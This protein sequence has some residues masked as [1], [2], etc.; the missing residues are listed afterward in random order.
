MT[1]AETRRLLCE[2]AARLRR[3]FP[4][5]YKDVPSALLDAIFDAAVRIERSDNLLVSFSVEG[6]PSVVESIDPHCVGAAT[7]ATR[8]AFCLKVLAVVN[9]EI[10]LPP[11]L[12]VV[13]SHAKVHS[14]RVINSAQEN[15]KIQARTQQ[16]LRVQRIPSR[17]TLRAYCTARLRKCQ[18]VCGKGD[19]EG[20]RK[21]WFVA[22]PFDTTFSKPER[23]VM[24]QVAASLG[25]RGTFTPLNDLFREVAATA[26]AL[27]LQTSKPLATDAPAATTS[28]KQHRQLLRRYLESTAWREL[29]CERSIATAREASEAALLL[30]T[31]YS[32]SSGDAT[33]IA[34]RRPPGFTQLSDDARE[35]YKSIVAC[36]EGDVVSRSFY[37]R[38]KVD[39]KDAGSP[40]LPDRSRAAEP[41]PAGWSYRFCPHVGCWVL[42]DHVCRRAFLDAEVR[43]SLQ[44]QDCQQPA[45]CCNCNTSAAPEQA[46][47]ETRSTAYSAIGF[48][49]RAECVA[50]PAASTDDP[51]S[52]SSCPHKLYSDLSA[53]MGRTVTCHRGF[54]STPS[55]TKLSSSSSV[56]SVQLPLGMH[57]DDEIVADHV[58]RRAFVRFVPHV[59]VSRNAPLTAAAAVVCC[60]APRWEW[61]WR[62]GVSSCVQRM[63]DVIRDQKCAAIA[64]LRVN[65]VSTS[66]CFAGV[67]ARIVVDKRVTPKTIERCHPLTRMVQLISEGQHLLVQSG[68]ERLLATDLLTR[69][70]S[71]LPSLCLGRCPD[72]PQYFNRWRHCCGQAVALEV[73]GVLLDTSCMSLVVS[74]L[75]LGDVSDSNQTVIEEVP[76]YSLLPLAFHGSIE[77]LDGYANAP[78]MNEF[79]ALLADA[80]V[81]KSTVSDETLADFVIEHFGSRYEYL[82]VSFSGSLK[83]DNGVVQLR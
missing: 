76:P 40:L 55:G 58:S 48:A 6:K 66:S 47:L 68:V 53:A 7:A 20:P 28:T 61:R 44:R 15:S 43:A 10:A 54:F 32:G 35:R 11:S 26:T 39:D 63:Y 37:A 24:M 75:R 52:H 18:E 9:C 1:P 70:S 59:S 8:Q 17:D 3:E 64:H 72:D 41:C 65:H 31:V 38:P 62:Q 60:A 5:K 78:A 16:Q 19:A 25:M 30:H 13:A 42:F 4:E 33:I 2:T 49:T 79:G 81:G 71:F 50:S 14:Y 23:D 83:V 46:L 74:V 67:D 36:V 57:G 56:L 22:P 80:V 34:C 77:V 51:T 27:L 12:W 45:A 82:F 29:R 21:L 69:P 73:V